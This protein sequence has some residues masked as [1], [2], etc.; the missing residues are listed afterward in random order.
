MSVELC[1]ECVADVMNNPYGF[2]WLNAEEKPVCMSNQ[3]RA[4]VLE[5]MAREETPK[6]R[7]VPANGEPAMSMVAITTVGGR[8]VCAF[9]TAER[10]WR[11]PR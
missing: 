10:A 4:L 3:G 5:A 2:N 1:A 6:F 11:Y 8:R 9:H 7:I